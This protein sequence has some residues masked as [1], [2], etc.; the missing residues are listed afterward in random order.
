MTMFSEN[1][2]NVVL[3]LSFEIQIAIY[4]SW[5]N[6]T[7]TKKIENLKKRNFPKFPFFPCFQFRKT[8]EKRVMTYGWN[9]CE[10]F[11]MLTLFNP[12]LSIHFV[13]IEEWSSWP[14]IGEQS[15]PGLEF[16]LATEARGLFWGVVSIGTHFT[17]GVH[18]TGVPMSTLSK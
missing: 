17:N 5:G 7:K 18:V 12:S 1:E 8:K 6:K 2:M 9:R 14:T 16:F 15:E 4:F 13:F 10:L 11:N 3:I